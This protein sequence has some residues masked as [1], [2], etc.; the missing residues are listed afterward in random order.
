MEADE[1]LKQAI[2]VYL[3]GN[4]LVVTEVERSNTEKRPDFIV[5]AGEVVS[6]VELKTKGEDEAEI[7]SRNSILDSG[8]VF[9]RHED[10]LRRNRLSALI[11][12]GVKQLSAYSIDGTPF[13]L[14]WLHSTGPYA[15][16][17]M[18]RFQTTLYGSR[19]IIHTEK[20]LANR[21]CYYFDNSDFFRFRD[22][23]DGAIISQDGS[24][25]FCI[26]D[27]SPRAQELRLS[28]L[29]IKMANAYC[30]P[31]E[32]E[33]ANQAYIV[34]G[35]VDRLAPDAIK[36]YLKNKYGCGEILDLNMKHYSGMIDT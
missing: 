21:W 29:P 35:D 36:T 33:S 19:E 6:I 32:F 34:D 23:L 2:R 27:L 5:R 14:L 15:S 1:I 11:R 17:M 28:C 10:S 7:R 20:Q 9:I 22:L 4:G 8:A 31:T 30:D 12:D 13:R 16:V 3:S 18:E 26:N 24:A 25:R